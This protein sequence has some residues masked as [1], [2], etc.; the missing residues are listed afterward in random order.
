MSD[1][2]GGVQFDPTPLELRR[3]LFE[4]PKEEWVQHDAVILGPRIP[5][6]V[7]PR[8]QFLRAARSPDMFGSVTTRLGAGNAP[9]RCTQRAM[10]PMPRPCCVLQFKGLVKLSNG[11]SK[12]F[13]CSDFAPYFCS[14]SIFED[15]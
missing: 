10:F 12:I 6:I 5:H 1:L 14:P 4:A 8:M 7:C 9:G 3:G 13:C 15:L 11:S 2:D